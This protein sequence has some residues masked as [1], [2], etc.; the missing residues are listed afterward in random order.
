MGQSDPK[1]PT[2]VLMGRPPLPTGLGR[3]ERTV[4]FLTQSERAFLEA[5]AT[6]AEQSISGY[7]HKLIVEGLSGQK[8]NT[9]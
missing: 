8:T 4:T 2:R 7:C 3:T 9:K 1:K 6:A 5:Q